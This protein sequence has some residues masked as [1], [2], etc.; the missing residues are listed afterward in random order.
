MTQGTLRALSFVAAWV[1][2][3]ATSLVMLGLV[4]RLTWEVLAFGWSLI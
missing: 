2:I 4:A 1:A 3:W